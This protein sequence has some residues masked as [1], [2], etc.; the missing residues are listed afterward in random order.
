[1]RR[2]ILARWMGTSAVRRFASIIIAW[3]CALGRLF[4][5]GV[6]R[7]NGGSFLRWP[8]GGIRFRRRRA[9]IDSAALLGFTFC[10]PDKTAFRAETGVCP[11]LP[12]FRPRIFCPDDN[13][14][15]L[16]FRCSYPTKEL[17]PSAA[18]TSDKTAQ[19]PPQSCCR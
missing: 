11:E 16:T 5:Q 6:S 1:M 15:S 19:M 14:G 3:I 12:R 18:S 7:R 9:E 17:R 13:R 10:T 2:R 4:R 8:C